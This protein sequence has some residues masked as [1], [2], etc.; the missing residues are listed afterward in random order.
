MFNNITSK[1]PNFFNTQ[2][3]ETISKTDSSIFNQNLKEIGGSLTNNIEGSPT[4]NLIDKASTFSSFPVSEIIKPEPI[5]R[6]DISKVGQDVSSSVASSV[7][8]GSTLS[9]GE[10]T[11]RRE[12]RAESRAERQ[13]S[14]AE[15][16]AERQE[17]KQSK[18]NV[19]SD[20]SM[21]EKRLKNI[22]LLLM[23]PLEVKIKN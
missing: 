6:E 21:L 15:S 13:E 19:N 20:F 3:N 11:S 17:S 8:S 12:S 5:T 14:R 4:S 9:V 22:E 7:A 1:S 23:G 10:D 18:V 2:Q 16:G